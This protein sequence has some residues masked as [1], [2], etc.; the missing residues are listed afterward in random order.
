MKNPWTEK[1]KGL[2]LKLN[3]RE[4]LPGSFVLEIEREIE[5]SLAEAYASGLEAAAVKVENWD[6]DSHYFKS[7]VSESIRSLSKEGVK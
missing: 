5:K 7:E 3:L 4:E 1:A 2:A 6:G